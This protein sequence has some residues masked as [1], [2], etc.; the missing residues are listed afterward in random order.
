[1]ASDSSRSIPTGSTTTADLPP[2]KLAANQLPTPANVT[3]YEAAKAGN[4]RRVRR[5][6]DN[7]A[8]PNWFQ[9]PEE[10]ATAMHKAAEGGHTDILQLLIE[11]GGVLDDALLTNRNTPL[12]IACDG[13]QLEVAKVLVAAGAP[14]GAANAFGNTPLHAALMSSRPSMDL[15][16]LLLSNGA[17]FRYANHRQSTPLHFLAYS[18][19]SGEEKMA[20]C[21]ILDDAGADVAAKDDQGMTPLHLAARDGQAALVAA[22][23][24]SDAPLEAVDAQ[25]H[26]PRYYAEHKGHSRIIGLLAEA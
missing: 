22:L 14:V 15:V 20:L 1:M 5:C 26:T 24:D 12:H 18:K 2:H 3:L 9:N 7:G 8:S 16:K 19:F 23:L 11:R 25:G 17:D 10:G 6:L 13:G 21:E 4:L